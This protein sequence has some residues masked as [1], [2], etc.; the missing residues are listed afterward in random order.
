[1]KPATI[2]QMRAALEDRGPDELRSM[3]LRMARYKSDN[4]ELLTYLLF[5]AGDEHG[6][7]E[8]IKESLD[9]LFA[10]IN[11]ANAFYAKKGLQKAAR[12]MQR[13]IRYSGQPATEVEIR[14]HFCENTRRFDIPVQ[15]SRV[16]INLYRRQIDRTEKAL[17]KLHADLQYDYRQELDSLKELY[18]L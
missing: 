1:M 12:Y 6:F 11:T 4:K 5:E 18:T 7:A 15:Q 13:W 3:I 16:M 10:G 9:E 17:K 8:H 14:L 2:H